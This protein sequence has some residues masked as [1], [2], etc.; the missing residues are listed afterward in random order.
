MGLLS[1][2][3]WQQLFLLSSQMNDVTARGARYTVS[4][5][6]MQFHPAKH[7]LDFKSKIMLTILCQH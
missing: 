1:A 3:F 2:C 4:K 5:K 7:C 6:Q